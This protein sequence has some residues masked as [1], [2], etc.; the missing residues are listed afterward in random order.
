VADMKTLSRADF[1]K[2]VLEG[3]VDKGMP[4]FNG[5]ASVVKNLEHLYAFLKGRSDG[6]IPTGNLKELQ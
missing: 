6:A 5:V 3:R 1:D 4:N 2:C